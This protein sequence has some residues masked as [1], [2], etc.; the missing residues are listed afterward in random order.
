MRILHII[1]DPRERLALEVALHQ[2][3]GHEVALLLIQD[4]VLVD[5]H[6]SPPPCKGEGRGEGIRIH[7]LSDDLQ[8]RNIPAPKLGVGCQML[9][10]RKVEGRPTSSIQHPASKVDY[11]GAVKLIFEY[12]K[13]IV[14]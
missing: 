14:W 7:A 3:E 5:P 13:V 8:A 11:E 1:R 10:L 2:A 6:L 12:D 4:G 9:D